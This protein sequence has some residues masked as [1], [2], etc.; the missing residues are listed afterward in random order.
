MVL[1]A[2]ATQTTP[3]VAVVFVIAVRRFLIVYGEAILRL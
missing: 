2:L 3:A 1:S